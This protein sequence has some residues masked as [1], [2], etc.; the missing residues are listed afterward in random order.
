MDDRLRMKRRNE[1]LKVD[2]K[3]LVSDLCRPTVKPAGTGTARSTVLL[4]NEMLS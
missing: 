2:A 4:G 3:A 1:V